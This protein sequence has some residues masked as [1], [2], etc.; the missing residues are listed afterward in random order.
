MNDEFYTKPEIYEAVKNYAVNEY[1][2]QGREIVRPFW[3]G[4][5]YKNFNYPI[6][7]VVIDNQPFSK[8]AE[9]VDFYLEKGIDFFLFCQTQRALTLLKSERD[10]TLIICSE[11]VKYDNQEEKIGTS[12]ITNLDKKYRVKTAVELSRKF[13]EIQ[14]GLVKVSAYKYPDNFVVGR[15]LERY[16]RNGIDFSIEKEDCYTKNILTSTDGKKV[17]A[18]GGGLVLHGK[19]VD[20]KKAAEEEY[21]QKGL[22]ELVV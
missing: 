12:F 8:S 9:I 21:E 19:A 13:R 18:F 10:I 7:G 6:G 1:S 22:I 15:M 2:L 20:K 16:A 5:D 11:R 17:N 14:G 4:G 3:K